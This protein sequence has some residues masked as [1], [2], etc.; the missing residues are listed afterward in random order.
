MTE[1]SLFYRH[2]KREFAPNPY[3]SRY[4]WKP[5]NSKKTIACTHTARSHNPNRL[6]R[7]LVSN[8][9]GAGPRPVVGELGNFFKWTRHSNNL[10]TL[11]WGHGPRRVGC[12]VS[13]AR[14]SAPIHQDSILNRTTPSPPLL[15]Q[16][17]Y[18]P[19]SL[20]A[21][22]KSQGVMIFAAIQTQKEELLFLLTDI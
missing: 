15:E 19:P 11:F 14:F 9:E 6:D 2:K 18:L 8:H 4:L 16:S 22:I 20:N 7:F 17:T 10:L 3:A 12:G 13:R 21:V 5:E 1:R